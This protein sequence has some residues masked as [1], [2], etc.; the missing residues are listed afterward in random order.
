MSF[1]DQEVHHFLELFRERE[2]LIRNFE[3]CTHLELWNEKNGSSVFFTYS[4]WKDENAL[5]QYRH[6]DLFKD[7]W[8]RTKALFA[9][10]AQAWSVGR[11]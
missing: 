10:P 3:G 5:E 2:S 4:H 1:R 8:K 9:H 7:T 11:V 6:S